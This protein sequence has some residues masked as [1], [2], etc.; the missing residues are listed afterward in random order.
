MTDLII[1][2]VCGKMGKAILEEA[3]KFDNIKITAGVDIVS[4]KSFSFPVYENIKKVKEHA[5]VIIDFSNHS[6]IYDILEYAIDK[7]IPIVECTTGHSEEE[8][9]L[10]NKTSKMIPVFKSGNMSI[11]INL[12][13]ELVKQAS[14][15]IGDEFDIEIV[16][17]HHNSK[18]DAPSGTALMIAEKIS[19]AVSFEPEYV[20]DRHEKRA[21]RQHN[22]IG[23]HSLRGGTVVGQHSV[24]FLGPNEEI[25]IEHIAESRSVFADGA[26]RAASFLVNK[27]SGLYDMS[28]LINENL[29]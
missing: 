22:E 19:D 2:G 28:D 3:V 5:D 16:E 17:T 29:K 21:K 13:I 4:N 15:V 18:L 7:E 26:L 11:G 9:Y 25:K 20:Y 1:C 6:A 12:L 8:L 23:I 10:I 24:H 14:K 27:K